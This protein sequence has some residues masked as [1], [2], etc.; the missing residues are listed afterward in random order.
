M[1][2][3]ELMYIVRPTV[4]EEQL[5][6]ATDRVDGMVA[7]LGGEVVDKQPWGKRR[8]AYP[9]EK[10][11]DGYYVVAQLRLEPT[12]TSELEEQLRIADEVIRHLLT[13]APEK[14]VR[15]NS[16]PVNNAP[17]DETPVDEADSDGNA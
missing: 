12:Q 15:A 7:T 4:P 5:T 2:E 10:H 9:I 3:Y 14:P 1:R 16:A 6:A 8:L 17:V 13:L 11:D